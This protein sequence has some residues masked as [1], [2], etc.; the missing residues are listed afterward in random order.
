[1]FH[2]QDDPSGITATRTLPLL[3]TMPFGAGPRGEAQAS[4]IN[5]QACAVPGSVIRQ[6]FYF[7]EE[8]GIPTRR[9]PATIYDAQICTPFCKGATQNT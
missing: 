7:F 4:Y 8:A 5:A 1:M 9:D 2:H 6:T 3:G